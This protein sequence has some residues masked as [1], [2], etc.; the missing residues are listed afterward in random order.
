M[1]VQCHT[2][3]QVPVTSLKKAPENTP[4]E[5]PEEERGPLGA[6][7]HWL[8]EYTRPRQGTSGDL[9][10]NSYIQPMFHAVPAGFAF[11]G[12]QGVGIAAGA[13][14]AATAV[15][16]HTKSRILTFAAGAA[17][18]VGIAAGLGAALGQPAAAAAL[19]GAGMLGG[20]QAFRGDKA[21]R[22][23]DASGNATLISGLFLPGT[24][25]IA[26]AV[27]SGV[28]A[29]LENKSPALQS[30]VGAATGAALGAGLAAMGMAP[31]GMVLTVGLSAAAGALGPLFGPRFS[32]GFRN[33]A[34]DSGRAV[35][36]GLEKAGVPHGK[37]NED[38]ANGIG[39]FPSQFLKE[40]LR[41]F[42]NSDFQLSGLLVGGAV[43]SLE[44]VELF[45]E[46]KKHPGEKGH[47]HHHH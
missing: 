9:E 36:A 34:N 16:R 23:R 47:H 21:A 20:V 2:Q 8:D 35:V 44:L 14:L 7:V 40:G 6:A 3:P 22:V 18:G 5:P 15:S 38:I 12:M 39:A 24:S 25:K 17:T 46:Q 28:G 27:A 37:I 4:P 31:G 42:I 26:G 30:L 43:E 32:Q 19:V 1:K 13:S 41:G 11:M 45:W 29:S 33:V 10:Q